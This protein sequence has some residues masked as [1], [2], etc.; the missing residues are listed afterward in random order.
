MPQ[1]MRSP[2]L[3]LV[4]N[5]RPLA[6]PLYSLGGGRGDERGA[7]DSKGSL[8]PPLPTPQLTHLPSSAW[9]ATEPGSQPG[10]CSRL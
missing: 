10:G 8:H 6:R 5:C 7:H 9:N 1:P 3:H 2:E 4:P